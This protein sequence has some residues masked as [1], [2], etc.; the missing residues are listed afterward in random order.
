MMKLKIGG[1][2]EHFNLPWRLAME[3]G[4][5]AE[6]NISLHWEDMAGGTGQMIRGLE[7][8]S[9]DV[10]V[11]LTEGISKAILEGLDAKILQV[12]VASPLHWGIH[13]GKDDKSIQKV[14]ELEG[15]TFAISRQGSG[16][17]LMAY[18][19]ADQK[20]WDIDKLKF[21]SVGDIYGLLWALDHN[22]ASAFLWERFTT[23]PY[24][25]QGKCRYIEDVV[26][27]WPCFVVAVRTEIAE[28]YKDE[29]QTMLEIVN[30]KALAIK[31]HE[32]TPGMLSWRYGQ[33]LEDVIKWLDQT[34]WNYD[35]REFNDDFAN[36]IDYLLKLKLVTAEQAENYQSKLFLK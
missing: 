8:K 5:F 32:G 19:L 34:E 6:G 7:N 11:L 28:K 31:N 23:K 4:D 12:Y 15:K 27:P 30:K 24:V 33:K 25:D 3:E 16:S 1:V 35:G 26:T 21:N 36:M 2:P 22:E 9:I 18:V 14:D 10:A 29:L 20:G 13:V 17:E